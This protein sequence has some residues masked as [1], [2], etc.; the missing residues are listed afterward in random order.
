MFNISVIGALTCLLIFVFL[1]F[2]SDH[3]HLPGPTAI[4]SKAVAVWHSTSGEIEHPYGVYAGQF[5]LIEGSSSAILLLLATLLQLQLCFP[6]I[7]T[8]GK[9]QFVYRESPTDG[10]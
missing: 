9:S 5:L 4:A 1:K 8:S 3:R 7:S 2:R 10:E 6:S